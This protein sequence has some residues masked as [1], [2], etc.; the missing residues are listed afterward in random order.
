LLFFTENFVERGATV[1][2]AAAQH[3]T[4]DIKRMLNGES[5]ALCC[6]IVGFVAL[7]I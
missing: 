2:P 7:L 5:I 3:A 1:E 6:G 4:V